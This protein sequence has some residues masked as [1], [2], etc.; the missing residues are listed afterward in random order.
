LPFPYWD[1]YAFAYGTMSRLSIYKNLAKEVYDALDVKPGETYLDAGCGTGNLL[2][3]ISEEGRAKAYGIDF[4]MPMLKQAIRKCKREN[5]TLAY[6]DLNKHLPFRNGFF[7]GIACVHTLY[8]LDDPAFT[9]KEFHRVLKRGA[10]LVL[11]NPRVD[12][13]R[14]SLMDREYLHID[15]LVYLTNLPS[16]ILLALMNVLPF[17]RITLRRASSLP[18]ETL[19]GLL[20]RV[21]FEIVRTKPIYEGTSILIVAK[22]K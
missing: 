12:A 15:G 8:L 18:N 4:S 17:K 13:V 11:A 21:S 22:K 19:K 3:K 9:L 20:R 14:K 10:G 7:D 5:V 1:L 2:L 6:S 16:C